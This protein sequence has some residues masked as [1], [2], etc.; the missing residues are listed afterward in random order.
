VGLRDPVSGAPVVQWARRREQ[1][2]WGAHL[3]EAP[4]VVAL[5][6]PAYKGASGLDELFEPVPQQI[7]D[8]YSGVHAMEG[9][10]AVAGRGVPAGVDLGERSIVDVA[11]TLLALL[12]RPVPSDS[13]GVV[14]ADAL[15]DGV[16]VREGA[17]SYQERAD[18]HE[19]LSAEEQATLE[20]S[21]RDLGYLE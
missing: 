21:L 11:P 2:Y 1:L 7:L 5:F 12:G 15:R 16:A 3:D 8:G 13:D 9:I 19:A 18:G 14:M 20:R 4:D 6:D 10:F 17:G